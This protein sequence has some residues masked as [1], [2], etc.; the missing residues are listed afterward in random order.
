MCVCVVNAQARLFSPRKQVMDHVCSVSRIILSQKLR[1]SN[2]FLVAPANHLK[3]DTVAHMEGKLYKFS[4]TL[5][6]AEL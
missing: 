5:S 6:A 4:D 2:F 1:A 3:P